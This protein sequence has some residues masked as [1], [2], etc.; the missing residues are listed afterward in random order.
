MDEMKRI[1]AA[2]YDAMAEAYLEQFGTSSVRAHWLA[3][4]IRCLPRQGTV[5][6]LG[7]GAGEPVA[8]NLADAGFDV[9]GVDV[10]ERQILI[11]RQKVPS[12]TF[13]HA[14]MM[15]I[16]L[17]AATFDGVAAFYSINHV[18][19][20][21][22]SQIFRKVAAWLKPGGVFLASLGV[23]GSGD[24]RGPWLGVEM[25]FSNSD[26]GT[27]LELIADAGLRIE[28]SE[29]MSQDNEPAEFLWV[30]GIKAEG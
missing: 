28:R 5:L 1:V 9:V 11:A 10:S 13:H 25:S 30:L 21:E 3:E 19:R 15:G 23:R 18:P 2:G 20:A 8:R 29:V 24:W 7:C 22:H 4:F 26:A 16:E 6:D 17:P 27:S 12:A 14:D